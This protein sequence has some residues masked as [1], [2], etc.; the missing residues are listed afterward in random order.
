M[1]RLLG[2]SSPCLSE[3]TPAGIN[4]PDHGGVVVV[5]GLPLGV[6]KLGSLHL[7]TYREQYDALGLC[8]LR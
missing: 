2:Y 5:A 6:Y 1:L 8:N 7:Y 3:A 4:L